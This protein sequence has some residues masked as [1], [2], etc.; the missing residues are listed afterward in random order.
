MPGSELLKGIRCSFCPQSRGANDMQITGERW[1]SLGNNLSH[2]NNVLLNLFY[3][4][5]HFFLFHII[6]E[7]IKGRKIIQKS[8]L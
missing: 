7:K 6:K 1:P 2:M 3:F 8:Q 5:K 4:F